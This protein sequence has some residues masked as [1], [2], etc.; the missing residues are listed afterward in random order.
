MDSE[1]TGYSMASEQKKLDFQ[2][3]ITMWIVIVTEEV[4]KKKRDEEGDDRDDDDDGDTKGV[5]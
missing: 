1:D 3:R 4:E 2:T 5:G